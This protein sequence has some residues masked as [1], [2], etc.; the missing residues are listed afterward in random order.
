MAEGIVELYTTQFDLSVTRLFI[1]GL[2]KQK[3]QLFLLH[4]SMKNE[5][6]C[7]SDTNYVSVTFLQS[8]DIKTRKLDPKRC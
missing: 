8:G 3:L 6:L 4:L 5:V 7:S 2:K 1:T